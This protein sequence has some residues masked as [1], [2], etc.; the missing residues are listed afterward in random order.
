MSVRS[1]MSAT[2]RS[3][4]SPTVRCG[5][6]SG[7]VPPYGGEPGNASTNAAINA[8]NGSDGSGRSHTTS[9]GNLPT[10]AKVAGNGV[11]DWQISATRETVES[12]TTVQNG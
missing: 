10:E 4:P 2:D 7:T 11:N 5:I 8:E 3:T 12:S 1:R 6:G 9:P